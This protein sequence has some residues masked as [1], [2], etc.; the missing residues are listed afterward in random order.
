MLRL[1]LLLLLSYARVRIAVGARGRIVLLNRIL[2]R[3]SLFWIS[4]MDLCSILLQL[5]LMA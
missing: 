5:L 3:N 1:L 4:N 2:S